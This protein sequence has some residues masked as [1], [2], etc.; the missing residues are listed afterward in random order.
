[1]DKGN[2]L[3]ALLEQ[4]NSPNISESA[5]KYEAVPLSVEDVRHI[6]FKL[7]EKGARFSMSRL[8]AK[9]RSKWPVA[10]QDKA[11]DPEREGYRR[12]LDTVLDQ[13]YRGA[14]QNEAIE[15]LKTSVDRLDDK[16]RRHLGESTDRLYTEARDRLKEMKAT[17]D[18]L[19]AHKIETALGELDRY[20]GTSVNDLRVFMRGHG[21]Q[22]ADASSPEEKRLYPELYVKLK[23]QHDKVAV[24]IGVQDPEPKK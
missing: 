4:L 17:I 15:A 1:M 5:L 2:A 22:F 11:F 23:Q 24:G 7:S 21:L 20:A 14:V 16:L 13:Q 3:N 9:A 10:F 18:M 6:P 19:K 8:T 12:A